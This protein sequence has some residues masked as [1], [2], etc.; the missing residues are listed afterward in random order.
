[1]VAYSRNDSD[2]GRAGAEAEWPLHAHNNSV[3]AIKIPPKTFLFPRFDGNSCS[4]LIGSRSAIF[5]S[6]GPCCCCP[7][8]SL[9]SSPLRSSVVRLF[10]GGE[11]TVT[12]LRCLGQVLNSESGIVANWGHLNYSGP[13]LFVELIPAPPF[14]E[15]SSMA[16][17][18]ISRSQM[19]RERHT[20]RTSVS[21]FALVHC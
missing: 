10:G 9:R 5:S 2:R 4:S 8:W 18:L 21:F 19:K 3:G 17:R 13:E 7:G 6:I 14:F 11:S 20:W 1:M 16:G 12:T 15:L